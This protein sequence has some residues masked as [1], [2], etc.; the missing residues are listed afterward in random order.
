MHEPKLPHLTAADPTL[1]ALIEGEAKRQHDK[2]RM[3]ASENY[4]STAVLEACGTV[5]NNKYSEGYPGK[6]YY[7]GQQF[8]DQVETLA[9]ERAKALFG[10]EHAN[11]QTYSG[12]PANLAVYLAFM[13]PGDTFLSLELAQGGHLTHGSPVSA[14]GKWFRPVHYTVGRD[15]GRIDMDLVRELALAERPKMIFCGGT[16][17]PRTIDFPAFAAIA[18]EVGAILVADIAHIAGLIAGGAHPSPVGHADVITT[19]TH[20]T[21]R[22][23]RGAM[24]MASAEHATAIDKAVFPGL[25]GGP[26][27]HTTA[28]IAVALHEAAQPTF[29]AYAHQVVANAQALATALN[30]RGFDLVSG[31]TDNHLLLIDLTGKGVEGKPAAKVLDAAG[32]ELNFNTVPYDPRKPWSPS[33]IR[34]GTAALTTRGLS[35]RHMPQVAAWMDDAVTAAVKDD[36]AAVERIAGEVRDLLQGFP[37]PGYTD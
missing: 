11:V 27:N 21:L 22:G 16:A 10:T 25:Q 2:L 32:I 8:C 13:T 26:H 1:A 5:L 31:G 37:M 33:G 3:I 6:R 9:I 30:D 12:S 4:V 15:S 29:T 7:E 14:T 18:R 28:G 35:E 17:I 24:I 20:K 23:P 19:T 34:L 36:T